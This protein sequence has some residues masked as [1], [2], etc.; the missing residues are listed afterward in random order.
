MW[1]DGIDQ[2][3]VDGDES[4]DRIIDVLPVWHDDGLSESY[5]LRKFHNYIKRKLIGG[6]SNRGDTLID[7]AVG[8][9][10]DLAKWTSAKLGFVFGID[11]FPDNIENQLND[12]SRGEGG[13][14]STGV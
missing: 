6:V 4:V 2:R 14:G 3:V 8:M 11:L 13:F 5:P 7:Y 1:N 12:S 10:G 9:G